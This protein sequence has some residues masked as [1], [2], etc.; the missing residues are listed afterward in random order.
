[1]AHF[2]THTLTARELIPREMIDHNG[3]CAHTRARA[4]RRAETNE[5]TRSTYVNEMARLTT[6]RD[7]ISTFEMDIAKKRERKEEA[8]RERERDGVECLSRRRNR[9]KKKQRYKVERIKEEKIDRPRRC[10]SI[11]CTRLYYFYLLYVSLSLSFVLSSSLYVAY[12]ISG[13][14]VQFSARIVIYTACPGFLSLRFGSFEKKTKKDREGGKERKRETRSRL[15]RRASRAASPRNRDS[16]MRLHV[17]CGGR[18][19]V[20]QQCYQGAA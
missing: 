13:E 14:P 17:E 16:R 11:L 7:E 2:V 5:P 15:F 6:S 10:L 8:E 4:M 9:R 12:R 20:H 19:D 18:E 3:S 1:M